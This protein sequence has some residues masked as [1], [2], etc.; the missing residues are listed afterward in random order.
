[1][2]CIQRVW[3]S[4][5]FVLFVV[6]VASVSAQDMKIAVPAIG[7]EP[8]ASISKE[9]GTGRRNNFKDGAGR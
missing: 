4:S 9:T 1:M 8:G 2:K 5:V 6:L 7:S 3:L